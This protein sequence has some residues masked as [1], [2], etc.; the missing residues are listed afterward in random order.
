MMSKPE[1][2]PALGDRCAPDRL[3]FV[4][5]PNSVELTYNVRVTRDGLVLTLLGMLNASEQPYG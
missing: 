3:D 1:C 2:P 5:H 4:G